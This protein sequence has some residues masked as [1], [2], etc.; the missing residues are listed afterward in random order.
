MGWSE[1]GSH[2]GQGHM[3]TAMTNVALAMVVINC[4]AL[5]IAVSIM[6]QSHR[7]N[8]IPLFAT[9]MWALNIVV[10]ALSYFWIV[11]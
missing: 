10:F 9:A 3:P 5:I 11:Q 1:T 6:R 7:P 2:E 4:T 8:T